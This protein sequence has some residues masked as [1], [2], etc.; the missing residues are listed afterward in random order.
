M[1]QQRFI[2]AVKCSQKIQHSVNFEN[3]KKSIPTIVSVSITSYIPVA[4]QQ[5]SKHPAFTN[6]SDGTSAMLHVL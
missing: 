2:T 1:I 5:C 6:K 4:V 3:T